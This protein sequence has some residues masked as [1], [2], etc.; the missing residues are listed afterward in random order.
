MWNKDE[1]FKLGRDT[2]FEK[3]AKVNALTIE[4]IYN[5]SIYDLNNGYI[6]LMDQY[7]PLW[8]GEFNEAG[9][10]MASTLF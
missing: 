4:P 10:I 3:C 1:L 6:K 8:E 7:R 2:Y 5:R 9:I